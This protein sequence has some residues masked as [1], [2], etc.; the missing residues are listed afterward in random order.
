MR[1]EHWLQ[2]QLS[3]PFSVSSSTNTQSKESMCENHGSLSSRVSLCKASRSSNE[4][5]PGFAVVRKAD[6]DDGRTHGWPVASR[7]DTAPMCR[8][9]KPKF[10]AGARGAKP[11]AGRKTRKPPTQPASQFSPE[12]D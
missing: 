10:Q 7:K 8:K 12:H 6:A 1:S 4:I 2:F 5:A 3:C 9:S 11:N